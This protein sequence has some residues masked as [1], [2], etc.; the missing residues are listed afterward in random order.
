MVC[1]SST[2]DCSLDA[3]LQLLD[4]R[5]KTDSPQKVVAKCMHRNQCATYNYKL[6]CNAK[7]FILAS[8]LWANGD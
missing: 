3:I 2:R 4:L 6:L 7:L 8:S 1:S 5:Q